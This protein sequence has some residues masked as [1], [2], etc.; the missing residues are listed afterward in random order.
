MAF[1]GELNINYYKGDTYEFNI[2]PKRA[3]GSVMAL[4]DYLP[5][6][7]IA[8]TR[9]NATTIECF[10][11]I[12]ANNQVE[13]AITPAAGEQLDPTKTYFYDVEIRK[14]DVSYPKVY[15]LLTGSITVTQQVSSTNSSSFDAGNK[16]YKVNYV[17]KNNTTGDIPVDSNEYRPGDTVTL[18]AGT[19][20]RNGYVFAGWSTTESLVAPILVAGST[21]SMPDSNL[22]LYSR[23]T[24]VP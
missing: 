14:P 24:L 19:L 7:K 9:G 12:N 2:T 15:T 8:E 17:D 21:T 13:C 6:F 22:K 18:L 23:W 11:S 1:P 20:Q 10:A 16:K 5:T 3:D 4:A